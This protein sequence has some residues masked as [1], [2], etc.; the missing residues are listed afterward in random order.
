MRHRPRTARDAA[1]PV[2]GAGALFGAVVSPAPRGE[3][4]GRLWDGAP[5]RRP[6]PPAVLTFWCVPH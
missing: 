4:A 1:L 3:A 6:A 2:E 5:P